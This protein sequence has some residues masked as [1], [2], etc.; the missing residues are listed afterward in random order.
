MLRN[1]EHRKYTDTCPF[2]CES[3]SD[4]TCENTYEAGKVPFF[5]TAEDVARI[6]RAAGGNQ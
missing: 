1:G 4:C 3:W 2:S 6:A 5:G